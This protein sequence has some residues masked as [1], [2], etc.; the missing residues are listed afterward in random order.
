ME[1]LLVSS[2][3]WGKLLFESEFAEFLNFQDSIYKR[4]HSV[5]SVNFDSDNL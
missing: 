5:N 4:H 3:L 1:K 2:F